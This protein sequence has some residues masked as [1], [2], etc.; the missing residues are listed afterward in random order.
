MVTKKLFKLRKLIVSKINKITCKVLLNVLH[1]KTVRVIYINKK[2]KHINCIKKKYKAKIF[3]Q[4]YFIIYLR[5]FNLEIIIKSK[6][7][8]TYIKL[9]STLE[10][11]IF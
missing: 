3:L 9:A 8:Q 7:K 2:F 11:L 4:F 5:S 10:I 6:E 1:R